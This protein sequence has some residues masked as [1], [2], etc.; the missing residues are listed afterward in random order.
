MEKNR[1]SFCR[2]EPSSARQGNDTEKWRE[3][4]EYL[5]FL[6]LWF[7][8]PCFYELRNFFGGWGHIS[9]FD[10]PN[11]RGVFSRRRTL[12]CGMFNSARGV[13]Q[14]LP[15]CTG[16]CSVVVIHSRYDPRGVCW[17][18]WAEVARSWGYRRWK[19]FRRRWSAV[20]VGLLRG[21]HQQ[22][23]RRWEWCGQSGR[24]G[25]LHR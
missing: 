24:Y 7:H 6:R 4:K 8:Q 5:V 9:R 21:G 20:H 3:N 1:V 17:T 11:L 12:F 19:R 23:V 25:L 14:I 2:F 18:S 10:S 15:A 22:S 16:Y 13:G